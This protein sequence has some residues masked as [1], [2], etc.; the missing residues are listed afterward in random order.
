MKVFYTA[1]G[2]GY[3]YEELF[4]GDLIYGGKEVLLRMGIGVGKPFPG[5][6]GGNKKFVKTEDPRGFAC[7]L[8]ICTWGA[9]PYCARIEHPELQCRW[10]EEDWRPYAAGILFRPSAWHDDYRGTAEAL[11]A[12]GLVPAGRF[13]GMPGMCATSQT[14]YANGT[15]PKND[16]QN[17]RHL[18]NS[19]GSMVVK[20]ISKN[21]FEVSITVPKEVGEKRLAEYL[22]RREAWEASM[23]TLPRA[24]RIDRNLRQEIDAQAVQRRASLHLVWSRPKFVPT[25]TLPPTGPHAR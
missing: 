13:P 12:T 3:S 22:A 21:H 14:F 7:K 8:E 16:G 6:P 1:D 11:T 23:K 20:K 19:A 18:K 2:Q 10:G 4:W 15:T 17:A 5:E 25:F 24:P 9:F